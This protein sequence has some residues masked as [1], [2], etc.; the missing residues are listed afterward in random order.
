MLFEQFINQI[1]SESSEED[2]INIIRNNKDTFQEDL[3]KL[4]EQ[5]CSGEDIEEVLSNINKHVENKYLFEIINKELRSETAAYIESGFIREMP[6]SD[7][8]PF[9]TF[10]LQNTVLKKAS[11]TVVID[12][13][14]INKQ[15]YGYLIKFLNTAIDMAVVR[16]FTKE[17]FLSSM[18]DLFRIGDNKINHIWN[19]FEENKNQLITT[20]ILNSVITIRKTSN[21]I[22]TIKEFLL[23]LTDD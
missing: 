2:I 12:Y 6:D 5:V 10:A 1:N 14:Q 18:Q 17:N 9:I 11:E 19:L 8:V 20:A 23:S 7:F 13:L 4:C 21:N 15:S 22:E 16:R 3:Y